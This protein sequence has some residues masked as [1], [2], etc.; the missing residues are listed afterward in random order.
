MKSQFC[1][2]CGNKV[3][4]S[5]A[6]PNFCSKCGTAMAGDAPPRQQVAQAALAEPP[7][8]E[9][10]PKVSRLE[11]DI[12]YEGAGSRSIKFEDLARQQVDTGDKS[13]KRRKGR[14]GAKKREQPLTREEFLV[15]SVDECRSVGNA[16]REIGGE[17]K[18]K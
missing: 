1:T 6:P 17:K 16:S 11:Y 14:R 12:N 10:V 15:K 18:Q 9:T 5:F 3:E 4:Y 7:P 8:Q 13:L 2:S